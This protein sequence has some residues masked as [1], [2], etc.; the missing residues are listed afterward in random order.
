MLLRVQRK[1]VAVD[2]WVRV[3]GV[4]VPRLHLVEVLTILLLETVLAVQDQLELVQRTHLQVSG[5]GALLNPALGREGTGNTGSLDHLRSAKLSR[6]Q[7]A[8]GRLEQSHISGYVH[9]RAVGAEV[10]QR[11]RLS[12][13]RVAAVLVSEYQLL[14]RVVE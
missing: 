12:Q 9:V 4:V 3:T 8:V 7:N 10:P 5:H 2:T 1:A 14:H 13:A 11:I 6:A